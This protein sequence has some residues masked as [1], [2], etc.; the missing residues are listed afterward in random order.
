MVAADAWGAGQGVDISVLR[1]CATAGE[2]DL[3]QPSDA[4]KMR[5]CLALWGMQGQLRFVSGG[6][7]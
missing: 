2:C 1:V 3:Q 4:E 5:S 6:R 7:L